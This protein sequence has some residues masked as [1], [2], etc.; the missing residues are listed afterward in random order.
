MAKC[1]M[2]QGTMSNV[3]KSLLVTALCR[4]FS[5]DGLRPVPFKSQNMALNSYVTPEGLELSRAQAVQ[6]WAAGLDPDVRMN[7]ILLKPSSDTGSQLIVNGESRGHY[8]AAD[9]FA[10]KRDLIPDVLSAYNSLAEEYDVIVIEGAGSPAEINLPADPFV[11]MGL[12]RLVSAPVLLAGD[13]DRGGV[14]AQLYGTVALLGEDRRYLAGTVINKFRGDVSLLRPG[15][16]QLEKLTGVPVLGVIPYV[17]VDIDDEDSLSP[18][19]DRRTHDA[20]VD[21]AVIRLPHIANFTDFAPLERHPALGVRYVERLSQLGRPDLVILP[22]TADQSC[23]MA[24][25][26]DSGLGAA[27]RDCEILKITAAEMFN[28]GETVGKLADRL[29]ERKGL[30]P[31]RFCPLPHR[32]YLEEQFKLLAQAVR[33]NLALSA[34]YRAMEKYERGTSL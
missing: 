10:M 15:L 27:I 23:D 2:V 28:S 30:K 31:M 6:A 7:P 25:L 1:I 19:L 33:E 32:D 4:I 8:Q 17:K 34:V 26:K 22:G 14:F 29:L 24:W 9:Y 5:Q 18:R 13:I 21:I 16:G 11:N 20:P 3:G 12:A